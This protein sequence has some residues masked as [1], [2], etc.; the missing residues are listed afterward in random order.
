MNY[1]S[2]KTFTHDLGLSCCFRQWKASSHCHYLHGYSL[3]VAM[4]F[5]A[6]SLDHRNWVMDFGGCK[7]I[8]QFLVKHFD[9]KTV[10]AVDDPHRSTFEQLR[11]LGIIDL[12]I[13]EAVGCE[14]F[15]EFIAEWTQHY[16]DELT[17]GR[18]RLVSVEVKEHGANSAIVTL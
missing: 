9:H 4:V 6:E 13:L 17:G 16:L 7:D 10:I 11:Q 3:E 15:A 5:S 1:L 2:T 12:V 14:K 18:V 8:K